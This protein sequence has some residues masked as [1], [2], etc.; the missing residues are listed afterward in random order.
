VDDKQLIEEH[1]LQ[2]ARLVGMLLHGTAWRERTNR[3]AVRRLLVG[4]ILAALACAAIAAATFIT[5]RLDSGGFRP[6]PPNAVVNGSP[7][8]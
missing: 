5:G 2:R 8:S 6:G 3:G 7:R 4:L 1:A